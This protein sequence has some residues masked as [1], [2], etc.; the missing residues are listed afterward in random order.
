MLNPHVAF[1]K[2][3]VEEDDDESEDSGP[4]PGNEEETLQKIS[5]GSY[6]FFDMGINIMNK[7]YDGLYK[8]DRKLHPN[9][10]DAVLERGTK[11]GVNKMLLMANTPEEVSSVYKLT[12]KSENRYMC[13]GINPS[14]LRKTFYSSKD[15]ADFQKDFEN[16]IESDIKDKSKLVAIG[17]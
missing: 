11:F 1:G 5:D 17:D 9:D 13:Y 3:R 10:V 2:R 12:E 16:K 15:E 4:P 7:Q 6:K 14:R 8:T